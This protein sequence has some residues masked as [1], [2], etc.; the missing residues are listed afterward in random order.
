VP[1][2]DPVA[3]A[4]MGLGISARGLA[5]VKVLDGELAS[6]TGQGPTAGAARYLAI[7]GCGSC[8]AP[9]HLVKGTAVRTGEEGEAP[10]STHNN[11]PP[12]ARCPSPTALPPDS[13]ATIFRQRL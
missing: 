2:Y 10:R 6:A 7:D 3:I 13:E 9:D 11:R 4:V 1:A 5:K 12:A 8:L